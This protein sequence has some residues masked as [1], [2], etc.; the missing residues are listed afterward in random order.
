M[1][2]VTQKSR[3]RY[4]LETVEAALIFPL[5]MLVI[6]GIVEYGWMF[7]KEH[8]ITNITRQAARMAATP[9]ATTASVN[10][11]V[12]TMMQNAQI[13][14]YGAPVYSPAITSAQ[15][16]QL[17]TVTITVPYSN[18]GL[19]RVPLLPLPASLQAQVAMNKE[20]P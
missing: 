10:A 8:Q 16:G 3:R 1:A 14:G 12:A 20:G 13:T 18:V 2:H 17:I 9:D 7:I 5:L 15:P 6:F 11:M 19:T 4:G